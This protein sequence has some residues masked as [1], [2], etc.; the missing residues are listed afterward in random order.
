LAVV[1][2]GLWWLCTRHQFELEKSVSTTMWLS[3]L[4]VIALISATSLRILVFGVVQWTDAT[5]S[6]LLVA[7]LYNVYRLLNSLLPTS[8]VRAPQSETNIIRG[9]TS[10]NSLSCAV[11]PCSR[12]D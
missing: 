9:S 1:S 7:Y 4:C 2:Y 11:S 5:A 10:V 3:A 6:I 8:I 12:H